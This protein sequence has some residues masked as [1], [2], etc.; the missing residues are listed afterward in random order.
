[1]GGGDALQKEEVGGRRGGW[2]T[3]SRGEGD[4]LQREEVGCVGGRWAPAGPG[5]RAQGSFG[6]DRAFALCARGGWIASNACSGPVP[7]PLSSRVRSHLFTQKGTLSFFLVIRDRLQIGVCGHFVTEGGWVSW[8]VGW[9]GTRPA[10]AEEARGRKG[11]RSAP[12]GHRKPARGA[13]P[14]S[15]NWGQVS[16]SG[17]AANELGVHAGVNASLGDE[18][19]VSAAF[20]DATVVEH[21]D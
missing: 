4:R 21:E 1:M 20:D 8:R 10:R 17:L 15:G 16:K 5:L 13:T 14:G 2:G 11:V 12:T 19:F 18:A 3:G 9:R 7:L 6:E